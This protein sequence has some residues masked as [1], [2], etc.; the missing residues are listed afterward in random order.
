MKSKIV[1]PQPHTP[2]I[3]WSKP[4]LVDSNGLIVATTGNHSE[5]NFEGIVFV[6]A[7][8]VPNRKTFLYSKGWEKS[9]FAPCRLPLTITF[10]ND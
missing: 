5:G 6:D 1:N 7:R 8:D 3:D 10:E 9:A 2:K 4:Q